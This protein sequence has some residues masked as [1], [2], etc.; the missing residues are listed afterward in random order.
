VE[1]LS[2]STTIHHQ[3]SSEQDLQDPASVLSSLLV[4]RLHRIRAAAIRTSR[5]ADFSAEMERMIVGGI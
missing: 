1:V 5:K 3:V 4:L 2:T